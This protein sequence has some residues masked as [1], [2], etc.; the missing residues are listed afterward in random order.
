MARFARFSP[1]IIYYFCYVKQQ[2]SVLIPYIK[3]LPKY[4]LPRG[5]NDYYPV[6]L[7]AQNGPNGRLYRPY[8]LKNRQPFYASNYLSGLTAHYIK[9]THTSYFWKRGSHYF[10]LILYW[11]V[12]KSRHQNPGFLLFPWVLL[13][14]WIIYRSRAIVSL[15]LYISNPPFWRPKTFI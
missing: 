10:R 7:A 3:L 5:S 12:M 14:Y 4:F 2:I 11:V 13:E 9:V 15:D 8:Y 1:K 6:N